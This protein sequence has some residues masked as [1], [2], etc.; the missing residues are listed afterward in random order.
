MSAPR[1][2]WMP[3]DGWLATPEGVDRAITALRQ[4]RVYVLEKKQ[5][6]SLGER[7]PYDTELQ[8]LAMLERD[9]KERKRYIHD[10]LS[11]EPD[12]FGR[13][14]RRV[15]AKRYGRAVFQE[16]ID[17]THAALAAAQQSHVQHGSALPPMSGGG[18]MKVRL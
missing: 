13:M 18:A 7:V 3:P 10:E 9:L 17:D 16:L 14:F 6:R 4:C 1:M 12:R 15:V 8:R 11:E 5:S 2:G